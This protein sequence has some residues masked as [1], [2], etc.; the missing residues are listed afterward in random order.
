MQRSVTFALLL[1]V[2]LVI[3]GRSP[4]RIR[5]R[6]N[7]SVSP[8]CAEYALPRPRMGGDMHLRRANRCAL[9]PYHALVSGT[10]PDGIDDRSPCIAARVTVRGMG[11]QDAGRRTRP[12]APL[13]LV[14]FAHRPSPPLLS[15]SDRASRL[16][17]FVVMAIEHEDNLR[18]TG[19]VNGLLTLQSRPADVTW[20]I[21]LAEELTTT[22]GET[23]GGMIDTDR[24]SPWS[25]IPGA[26]IRRC[27]PEALAQTTTGLLASAPSTRT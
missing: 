3:V 25:G 27:S 17:G 12:T 7:Q 23:M 5:P 8:R 20:E 6:P 16:Q 15:V 13:P 18:T 9:P 21:D 4:R 26:Q 22:D 24:K 10:N 19:S 2:C 1:V 11:S 14:V